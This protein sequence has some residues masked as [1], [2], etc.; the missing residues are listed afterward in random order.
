MMM[1]LISQRIS[2]YHYWVRKLEHG[3]RGKTTMETSG[4][5]ELIGMSYCVVTMMMIL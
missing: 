5:F 1:A 3:Q 2:P 4:D